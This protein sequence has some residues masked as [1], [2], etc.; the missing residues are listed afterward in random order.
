MIPQDLA[1]LDLHEDV[2]LPLRT[3][4]AP[5]A[6][7]REIR[8]T[9]GQ[10]PINLLVGSEDLVRISTDLFEAYNDWDEERLDL[11]PELN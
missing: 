2:T 8:T 9:I 10:V 5:L 3:V 1:Q 4:V 11:D 6:I 7:V